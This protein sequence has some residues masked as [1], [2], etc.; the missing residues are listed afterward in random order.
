MRLIG[1]DPGLQRTGWGVI[2]MQGNRLRLV[3]AGIVRSSPRDA[4]ATRLLALHDGL[5]AAIEEFS[6]LE[7]AVE[8]TYVNK[9][10]ESTLKLGQARGIALMTPA[11]LGLPV[12]E[13]QAM[14]VKKAVVGYGHA[15]KEQVAAMVT[16]LLPGCEAYGHDAFDALALAICHAH[17][18]QTGVVWAGTAGAVGESPALTKPHA[19]GG[20]PAG[21]ERVVR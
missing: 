4:L 16:R 21:P 17:N 11:K 8:H 6:P 15:E 12:A 1:I 13:Y 19:A 2:A 5:V 14:A 3:A 9:N 18:R 10:P 7:A 20:L